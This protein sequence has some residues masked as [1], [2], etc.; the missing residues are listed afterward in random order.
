MAWVSTSVWSCSS[1]TEFVPAPDSEWPF[2]VIIEGAGRAPEASGPHQLDEQSR[3]FSFGVNGV[4]RI[5][6]V[7]VDVE[8]VLAARVRDPSS[9][10]DRVEL[11]FE[12]ED[13]ARG[14]PDADGLRVPLEDHNAK[15]FELQDGHFEPRALG[16]RAMSLWIPTDEAACFTTSPIV[17]VPFGQERLLYPEGVASPI[18]GGVIAVRELPDG[19]LVVAG[20]QGL[21]IATPG[22]LGTSREEHTWRVNSLPSGETVRGIVS[23]A[24]APSREDSN[25]LVIVI[26]VF[27]VIGPD[28]LPG[29][30]LIELAWTEAGFE[31]GVVLFE[32]EDGFNFVDVNASGRWVAGADDG[33][34][35]LREPGDAAFRQVELARAPL[36]GVK[37]EGWTVTGL[38]HEPDLV[39][40]VGATF[41]FGDLGSGMEFRQEASPL[42]GFR[43]P[44]SVVPRGSSDIELYWSAGTH[45]FRHRDVNGARELITGYLPPEMVRCSDP[46][47]SCDRRS[48]LQGWAT[49]LGLTP[50]ET[51]V[52]ATSNCSAFVEY[53]PKFGCSRAIYE[54]G[55][56]AEVT[57]E[58]ITSFTA[59]KRGLYIGGQPSLLLFAPWPE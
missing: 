36:F 49:Y 7:A 26:V 51:L 54:P 43:P 6:L 27:G 38:A 55:V 5:H 32:E 47:D 44:M 30:R 22:Q 41:H 21:A 20:D 15:L 59:T 3:R 58:R 33:A 9:V 10:A 39:I 25:R 13:C 45:E 48:F 8:T 57:S 11:R 23:L 2:F 4:D 50:Q 37:M 24:T 42:G 17:P 19:R 34:V 29:A 52:F 53:E 46:P 18:G 12:A 56:G 40:D 16:D 28:G 1:E 31:P 14:R 35:Y